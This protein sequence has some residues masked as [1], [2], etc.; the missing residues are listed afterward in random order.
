MPG[1]CPNRAVKKTY[2][3]A[4]TSRLQL[5][6]GCGAVKKAA[7]S[8]LPS[9]ST[10]NATARRAIDATDP[11]PDAGRPS[12]SPFGALPAPWPVTDPGPD[13]HEPSTLIRSEPTTSSLGCYGV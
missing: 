7:T 2:W 5:F 1:V 8:A 4:N 6:G 11:G 10:A 13:S 3:T 12:R 9:T